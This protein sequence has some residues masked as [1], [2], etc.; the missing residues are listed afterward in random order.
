M[1]MLTCSYWI[2]CTDIRGSS[3]FHM[4]EMVIFPLYRNKLVKSS[5]HIPEFRSKIHSLYFPKQ[6]LCDEATQR[7]KFALTRLNFWKITIS[8]ESY[9]FF[10]TGEESKTLHEVITHKE[11][12]KKQ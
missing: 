10:K 11:K 6:S 12:K 2:Y 5:W 8:Y 1:D 3:V 4:E 7:E 9:L